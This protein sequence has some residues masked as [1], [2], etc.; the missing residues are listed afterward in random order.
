[1]TISTIEPLTGYGWRVTGSGQLHQTG[2][3]GAHQLDRLA[4]EPPSTTRSRALRQRSR[5]RRRLSWYHI[6]AQ[7]ALTSMK[8]FTVRVDRRHAAIAPS[9]AISITDSLTL[10]PRREFV[11][12]SIAPP[13]SPW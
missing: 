6:S 13:R 4:I 11:C 2:A 9:T 3:A 5:P 8:A 7:V 12:P 10:L 1:M